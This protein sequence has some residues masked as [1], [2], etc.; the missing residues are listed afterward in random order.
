MQYNRTVFLDGH[1]L[2]A[3][4]FPLRAIWPLLWRDGSLRLQLSG[5][6][7]WAAVFQ[8]RRRRGCMMLSLPASHVIIISNLEMV[9]IF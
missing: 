6:E 2:S 8:R 1:P 7:S 4:H 5:H 3:Q 9:F